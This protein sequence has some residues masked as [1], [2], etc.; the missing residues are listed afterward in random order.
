MKLYGT[1]GTELMAV[2]RIRRDGGQLL[3]KG[4]VF[5]TMPMTAVLTPADVRAGLKLLGWGGLVFMLTM[6]FR[7]TTPHRKEGT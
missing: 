2:S 7:S 4:K 1:D 6:P 3:I 5:G